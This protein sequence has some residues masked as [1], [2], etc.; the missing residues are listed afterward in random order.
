MGLG[1]FVGSALKRTGGFLRRVG[2][3]GSDVLRRF[4]AP[5]GN[6]LK[7]LA[8]TV[9]GMVPQ[10]PVTNF[11]S[12]AVNKGLD[13]LGSGRAADDVGKLGGVG[14]RVAAYGRKFKAD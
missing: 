11:A 12:A 14:D 4:G 10:N 2:E 7:P 6:A 13:Y 3:V 5:L 8:S 1:N 9:A